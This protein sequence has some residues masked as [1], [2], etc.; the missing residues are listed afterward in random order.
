MVGEPEAAQSSAASESAFDYGRLRGEVLGCIQAMLADEH[1]HCDLCRDLKERIET[2]A[3]NLLVV[4]QFKRGKTLLINAL[5][6]ADIL[7]VA[8]VPLTSIVTILTFGS[9]LTITVHFNDGRVEETDLDDLAAYVTEIGNPGNEKNV[10]KVMITYPSDYLKDGVR[11]IDT[12]GVG[13]VFQHNTDVAYQWLP[14]S[15][16]AL[17]LLSVDQPVSRAEL[18][19]LRDVREYSQ[20]I[21]FLL[22]KIDYVTDEECRESMAFSRRAV[23]DAMEAEVR[24]F[25][26]SAKLA[27]KGKLKQDEDLLRR[28]NISAFSEALHRFLMDEKGRMLLFSASGSAMRTLSQARL[29]VE[30]E[31]KS[32]TAPLKELEE[33]IGIFEAKKRELAAGRE[34]FNILLDGEVERIVKVHLDP[35]LNVFRDALTKRVETELDAFY[36]EN[37]GLSLKELKDALEA[38]ATEEMQSSLEQWRIRKDEQLGAA[39]EEISRK[40][41][42]TMNEKVEQLLKFSS[43]LFTVPFESVGVE[44]H[45]NIKAGFSFKTQLEPV[46]LEMLDDAMT[47]MLPKYISDRFIKLKNFLFGMANKRIFNKVKRDAAQTVDMQ[48]G[49]MRYDFIERLAA[50]KNDLRMEMLHRMDA[51]MDGVERAIEKGME[52]RAGG[53]GGVRTRQE[54][55]EAELAKMDG[56]REDIL[57]IRKQL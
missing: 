14:Q 54:L 44:H 57:S 23:G 48:S 49:R 29:E 27:L 1:I 52:L 47:Q 8:V 24:I 25:P 50:S 35:E 16:A 3:F 22:N 53:E 7:P 30:L 46:G 28:S 13:S 4:G 9:T 39:M 37:K 5:L 43:Q 34:D 32:L 11:L 31:L 20:R 41:L 19:F 15:D 51:A 6:G 40:F 12:P 21:F 45:W 18:D 55:L 36:E 26:V 17:F 33:K 38:C 42:T 2:N 56:I 10:S